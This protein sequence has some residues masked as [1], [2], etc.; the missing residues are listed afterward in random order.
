M[1]FPFS[2]VKS[3]LAPQLYY[4]LAQ[5][6]SKCYQILI[7]VMHTTLQPAYPPPP[8]QQVFIIELI[9][10]N[11]TPQPS[12]NYSYQVPTSGYVNLEHLLF[13]NT[14]NSFNLIYFN[15]QLLKLQNNSNIEDI[16]WLNLTSASLFTL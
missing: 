4:S 16:H 13:Q 3:T 14:N 8:T 6:Y 5:N 7:P 11:F 2:C 1:A 10:L 9:P 12:Y 15:I